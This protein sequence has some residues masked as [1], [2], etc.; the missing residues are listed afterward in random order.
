MFIKVKTILQ[1]LVCAAM[2]AQVTGCIFVDH[3]HDHWHHDH[4]PAVVYVH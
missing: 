4:P 1:I 3:D 2:A